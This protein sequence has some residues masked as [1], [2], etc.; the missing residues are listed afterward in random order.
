M[1]KKGVVIFFSENWQFSTQLK[2]YKILKLVVAWGYQILAA[3]EREGN[4]R[5]WSPEERLHT[6]Y[7]SSGAANCNGMTGYFILLHQSKSVS[8]SSTYMHQ[9]RRGGQGS[10]LW[11]AG[12]GIRRL[13]KSWREVGDGRRECKSWPGNRTSA[14]DKQA[15]LA[16]EFNWK[17]P[18]TGRLCR[19]QANGGQKYVLHAQKTSKPGIFLTS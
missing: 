12:V 6:P 5:V 4:S 9:L 18:Q 19:R 17:W 16:W 14:N 1:Q 3:N 11:A 7:D 10:I 13:P 2:L 8:L 15:Q